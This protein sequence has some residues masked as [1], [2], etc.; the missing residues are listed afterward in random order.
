[1]TEIVGGKPIL[2]KIFRKFDRRARVLER[3]T[4]GEWTFADNNRLTLM[5]DL[6]T[7][8]DYELFDCDFKSLDWTEFCKHYVLGV[9]RF[10]LQ[11][12]IDNLSAAR[13]DLSYVHYRNLSL[14]ILSVAMGLYFLVSWTL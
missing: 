14:Q 10:L 11:E 8:R 13:R 1:M 6:M 3:F 7:K 4:M 5:N 9:R 2:V 12:P